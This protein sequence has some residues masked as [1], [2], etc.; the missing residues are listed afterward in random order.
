VADRSTRLRAGRLWNS[1]LPGPRRLLPAELLAALCSFWR[2]GDLSV[3]AYSGVLLCLIAFILRR[4]VGSEKH[5]NRDGAPRAP[6]GG[7]ERCAALSGARAPRP[8]VRRDLLERSSIAVE[9]KNAGVRV[10]LVPGR[11]ANDSAGPQLESR[12]NGLH[13]RWFIA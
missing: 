13:Q 10:A 5:E 3:L 1:R 11:P 12:S 9:L 6:D 2:R 8:R 4:H 7:M